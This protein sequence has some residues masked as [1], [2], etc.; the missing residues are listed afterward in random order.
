[1]NTLY[2]YK[3]DLKQQSLI[4]KLKLF[5][6]CDNKSFYKICV[7]VIVPD[8]NGNEQILLTKIFDENAFT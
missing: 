1:M 6:E 5:F 3:I 2:H 8:D 7:R 4:H